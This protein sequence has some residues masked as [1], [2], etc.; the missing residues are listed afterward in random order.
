[1]ISWSLVFKA[2]RKINQMFFEIILLIGMINYGIT[3]IILPPPLSK[4]SYVP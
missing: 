3:A 4:S 1:M 2:A